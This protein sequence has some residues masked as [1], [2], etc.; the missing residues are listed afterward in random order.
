MINDPFTEGRKSNPFEGII[1]HRPLVPCKRSMISRNLP[2]PG[3]R[4]LSS[5]VTIFPPFLVLLTISFPLFSVQPPPHVIEGTVLESR[6]AGKLL[7]VH[8]LATPRGGSCR[9]LREP[10]GIPPILQRRSRE[11]IAMLNASLPE[12]GDPGLG[13]HLGVTVPLA[14]NTP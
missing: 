11:F 4:S 6:T 1:Q 14:I 9:L 3:I 2:L 7:K 13:P 12:G 10:M 8:L 5:D